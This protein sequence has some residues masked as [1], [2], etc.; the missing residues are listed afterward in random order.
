MIANEYVGKLRFDHCVF[1]EMIQ[2]HA[3]ICRCV[4]PS[5]CHSQEKK[6]LIELGISMAPFCRIFQRFSH[7]CPIQRIQSKHPP[8]MNSSYS[9]L[10]SLQIL[11]RHHGRRH[12]S[13]YRWKDPGSPEVIQWK[14]ELSNGPLEITR[15]PW[16]SVVSDLAILEFLQKL[17]H[18][19]R[20][21]ATAGRRTAPWWKRPSPYCRARRPPFHLGEVV[22][23]KAIYFPEGISNMAMFKSLVDP[24]VIWSSS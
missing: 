23:S 19:C 8:E 20:S 24:P 18:F 17:A 2:I 22:I 16:I 6:R 11:Q 21:K 3:H 12:L 14:I 9:S 4:P 7:G 13:N 5:V 15:A 10:L 1:S